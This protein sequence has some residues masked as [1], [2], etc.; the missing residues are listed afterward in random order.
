MSHRTTETERALILQLILSPDWKP[1]TQEEEGSCPNDVLGRRKEKPGTSGALGKE[2][3]VAG[4]LG[5][6]RCATRV[7]LLSLGH[8]DWTRNP[9]AACAQE[10]RRWP[11]PR[12]DFGTASQGCDP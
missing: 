11:C 9:A 1:G 4:G 5:P 2:P 10:Q 12:Q 3:G 6:V 8:L 7:A